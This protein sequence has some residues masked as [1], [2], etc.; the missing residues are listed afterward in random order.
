MS[1]SKK[2]ANSVK[3][4]IYL[5]EHF[6]EPKQSTDIAEEIESNASKIRQLL[7]RLVKAELVESIK[8]SQGGFR[9]KN[10][11]KTFTCKIF[12]VQLKIRKFFQSI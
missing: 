9:L 7:S 5:A 8:G 1:A 2:L 12:I 4:L 10:N 11:L 3:A 6:P